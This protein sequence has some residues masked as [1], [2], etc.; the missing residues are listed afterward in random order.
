MYTSHCKESWEMKNT[1]LPPKVVFLEQLEISAMAT[2]PVAL[3]VID[4][5]LLF[6]VTRVIVVILLMPLGYLEA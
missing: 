6:V 5:Y 2:E 1:F 3:F 4:L